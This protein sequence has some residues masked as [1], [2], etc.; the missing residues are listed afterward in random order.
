MSIFRNNV[1]GCQ[2]GFNLIENLV[3]LF[4]L[5]VGLL[6]VA[7][8]QAVALKT[9]QQSHHY[10]KALSLAQEMAG[11]IRANMEGASLGYYNMRQSTPTVTVD[12]NSSCM[13]ATGCS[14]IEMTGHDLWEWQRAVGRTLP[15]GK[16]FVCQDSTPSLDPVAYVGDP[17]STTL[18]N[19]DNTGDTYM[20]H[21]VWDMDPDRDG[22]LELTSSPQT[23]DGHLILRFEP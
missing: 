1:R 15:E 5:S 18:D 2:Q 20:I 21:L 16:G 7:G 3:T 6:G 13:N 12:E 11:R 9:H 10:D 23:S 19:C 17:R 22:S 14:S 8:M 4:I